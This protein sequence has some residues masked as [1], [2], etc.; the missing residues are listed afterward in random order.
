MG[1]CGE[2]RRLLDEPVPDAMDG[3]DVPGILWF[4]LDF[5]AQLGHVHV[6]GAC[7]GDVL[8]PPDG[9]ERP[10]P[11][12]DFTTVLY[13]EL[14]Q[15]EL[16]V[17]QLDQLALLSRLELLEVHGDVPELVTLDLRGATRN[18]PHDR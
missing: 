17:G 9:I 5:L 4:R 1:G 8:I 3:N 18:A 6:D 10:L 11:R 7:E 16:A 12:D 2:K 14:Q 15:F 13:E